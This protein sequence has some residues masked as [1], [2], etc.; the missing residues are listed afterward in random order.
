MAGFESWLQRQLGSG[1]RSADLVA[2][3]E[4]KELDGAHVL[5]RRG[6][7]ADTIDFVA[8]GS[9]A[10]DITGGEGGSLRVRRIM[11]HSVVGE[12]GFF[13]RS[14]RSATVCSDGPATVFTITRK[15]FER[16]RL[17]RPDL[18]TAFYEFIIGVLA[19]RLEFSDRMV[20]ALRT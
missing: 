17:E 3:C 6:E 15:D 10:V 4:R 18:A 7:A 19:E 14:V 13:R 2:Y 5:Y 11:T 16:M 12:M 8:S 20:A 9:L 1:V